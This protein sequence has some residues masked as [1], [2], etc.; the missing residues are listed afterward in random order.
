M[1]DSPARFSDGPE[2]IDFTHHLSQLSRERMNSPLKS[3]YK[4]VP[5]ILTA[6]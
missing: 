2:A 3:L 5:A 6:G 1:P 4:C